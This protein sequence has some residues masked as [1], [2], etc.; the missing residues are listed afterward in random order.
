MNDCG[1]KSMPMS[2]MSGAKPTATP[3]MSMS[4]SKTSPT[5][6][7]SASPTYNAASGAVR[8]GITTVLGTVVVAAG[9]LL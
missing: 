4:G 1:N 7:A 2:T 8:G 3:S 6:S 5:M 9:L